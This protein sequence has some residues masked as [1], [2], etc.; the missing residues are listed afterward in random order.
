MNRIELLLATFL[1][2][3]SSTANSGFLPKLP[4]FNIKTK[5]ESALRVYPLGVLTQQAAFSHHGAPE[6]KVTLP[7][8]KEGWIYVVG[9]GNNLKTYQL[10]SGATK[11]VK[12]T[13]WE[14]GVRN[15]TLVFDDGV[16]I[17]VI[18]KDDG[19]DIGVTAMELQHPRPKRDPSS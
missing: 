4:N 1:W 5:P 18:Y 15:F 6:K 2:A 3:S 16:V 13:A 12:E 8:G 17:D 7:N 19:N 11:T 10:P 14:L 9:Y